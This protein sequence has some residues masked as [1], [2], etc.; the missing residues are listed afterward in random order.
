MSFDAART[1]GDP[2]YANMG[3][4]GEYDTR[5]QW[6]RNG[7]GRQPAVRIT[8]SAPVKRVWYGLDI[9]DKARGNQMYAGRS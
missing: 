5:V 1:Y 2:V 3:E 4:Q 7:S 8:C 6:Q 9:G